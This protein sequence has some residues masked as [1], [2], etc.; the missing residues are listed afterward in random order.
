MGYS[1]GQKPNPTYA[2]ILDS[3]ECV[4][5]EY[6]TSKVKYADLIVDVFR[7]H[8]PVTR[9]TRQYRT[10]LFY[11][12]ELEKLICEDAMRCWKEQNI[13]LD[14]FVEVEPLTKF[15]R[16]EEYHQDYLKKKGM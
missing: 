9:R 6:D 11:G 12:S 8:K 4:R 2:R 13:G 10:V 14:L 7:M 3:T 15:Y 1:G 5:I 16:A